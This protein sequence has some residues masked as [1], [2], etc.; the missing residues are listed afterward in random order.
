MFWGFS[1][2]KQL[3]NWFHLLRWGRPG[4]WGSRFVGMLGKVAS[5]ALFLDSLVKMSGRRL[6]DIR[7]REKCHR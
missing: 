3:G 2:A 7:V 1:L 4:V 6:L 5:A